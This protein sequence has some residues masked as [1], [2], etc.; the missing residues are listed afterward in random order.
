[1]SLFTW[2]PLFFFGGIFIKQH[3][4]QSENHRFNQKLQCS[5][6]AIIIAGP[7]ITRGKN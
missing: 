3:E 4:R 7:A 6:E 1:M 2:L 5:Y